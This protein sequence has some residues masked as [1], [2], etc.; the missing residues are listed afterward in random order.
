MHSNDFLVRIQGTLACF[1]RPEFSTERVSYDLITPSAARGVL[2]AILWKPAIRWEIRRIAL[3]NPV[4]YAR[5]RRNEVNTRLSTQNALAEAR[6]GKLMPDFYADEDR[7][8]R[9]TVALRDVDYGIV[10]RFHMTARAGEGD[11]LRKFEEMFERRLQKGQ[12][13]YQPY[14]GCREFPAFV[15]PWHG[16]GALEQESR[17]LGWMLH[18]IAFGTIRGKEVANQPRFFPAEL[19]RGVVDVPAWE[20]AMPANPEAL[21]V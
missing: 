2:E 17:M 7:A 3:L 18:D 19:R 9:N 5:F 15:E 20:D 8:Q 13:H 10:A 4:R 6:G 12:Q 1:T 14:L 21:R 16:T 11:N